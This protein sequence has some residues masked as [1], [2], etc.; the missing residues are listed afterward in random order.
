[1]LTAY[2]KGMNFDAVFTHDGKFVSGK[3]IPEKKNIGARMM[4]KK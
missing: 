4:V 3:N 2:V 1:M